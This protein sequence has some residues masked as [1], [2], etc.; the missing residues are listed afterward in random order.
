MK[1]KKLKNRKRKRSVIFRY[2]KMWRSIINNV[3]SSWDDFQLGG[4]RPRPLNNSVSN[5]EDIFEIKSEF[6]EAFQIINKEITL[7]NALTGGDFFQANRNVNKFMESLYKVLIEGMT[8]ND[9]IFVVFFHPSL[10]TPISIPFTYRDDLSPE[11]IASAFI[12]VFQSNK[13]LKIDNNLL[14]RAKIAKIPA[15]SQ[16][17]DPN[18]FKKFNKSMIPIINKDNL[19]L[20][21]AFFV[22]KLIA[23]NSNVK[24]SNYLRKGN[25]Q[26]FIDVQKL[27]ALLNIDQTKPCGIEIIK[28]IKKLYP[29]YDISIYDKSVMTSKEKKPILKTEYIN[30]EKFIYLFFHENHYCTIRYPAAF[31]GFKSF[32]NYC[33]SGSNNFFLHNC[34]HICYCCKKKDCIII[35]NEIIKCE[36][37]FLNCKSKACYSEHKLKICR[38]KN[39]CSECNK[40]YL[41]NHICN[42]ESKYCNNCKK[43]VKYDHRCFILKEELKDNEPDGWIFFDYEATQEEKN[44]LPNLVIAHVYDKNFLL[45]EKKFFYDS[46]EN[47]NNKFCSW[48][49]KKKNHICLCHNFKG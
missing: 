3:Y 42:N 33:K 7:K 32:C 48:L 29:E 35:E 40:E 22:G 10:D 37:C 39:K 36:S 12:R 38:P 28:E 18:L 16:S 43:V 8:S 41:Y 20:L 21:R 34:S 13:T 6:N 19:C 44:H 27:A 31:L 9:K 47:V 5:F 1:I 26:C 14:I 45:V 15:G 2:K 25:K 4:A 11:I 24:I 30:E 46:G 17:T 23:D 49:F